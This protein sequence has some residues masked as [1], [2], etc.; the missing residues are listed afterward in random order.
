MFAAISA[1]APHVGL[2]RWAAAISQQ[3]HSITLA[4]ADALLADWQ[5][6]M[7][8]PSQRLQVWAD[9]QQLFT[10][11]QLPALSAAHFLI[12]AAERL[13]QG[14]SLSLEEQ[15]LLVRVSLLDNILLPQWP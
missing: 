7:W 4:R 5:R 12:S 14:G 2:Y 6:L 13:A 15:V 11:Q 1:H 8:L 3:Q 10:M 9:I